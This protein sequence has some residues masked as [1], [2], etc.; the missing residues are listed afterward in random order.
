MLEDKFMEEKSLSA[1]AVMTLPLKVREEVVRL[2]HSRGTPLSSI[3]EIRLRAEGKCSVTSMSQR[4]RLCASP[5]ASE[6][7]STFSHICKSSLYAYRDSINEGY[8]TLSEGVRVGICGHARY[9]G[10]KLLGVSNIT[11][12]VYRIPTAA[13]EVGELIFREWEGCRR[14][15]LVYSPPG[16]GKTSALRSLVGLAAKKGENIAV[17]DERC[18]FI[19]ADYRNYSV[20]ILRGYKRALGMEIALRT[21]A[22]DG[23]AIDEVGRA[24]EASGM[25]E[26]MNAG[27]RIM[28]TAHASSLEELKNRENLRPLF[29]HR[30]FDSVVG[31]FREGSRRVAKIERL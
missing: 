7:E 23:I 2:M 12:L 29:A 3:S 8:V 28:A 11:S 25:L 30:I 5:T 4:I 17:I 22:P 13:S 27:V 10:D 31:L 20:D 9:E 15:I 16:G 21:L 18:E 14:G 26:S 19:A 1:A 6:V 24:D